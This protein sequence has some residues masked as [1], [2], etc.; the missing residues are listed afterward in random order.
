MAIATLDA[1]LAGMRPPEPFFKATT[2]TLVAG[3]PHSLWYLAGFPGAGAAAANT[4]GG[5]ALSSSS[6]LVA[7]Q[8]RHIDPGGSDVSVL[9]RFSGRVTSQPGHLLLCDR[10]M[11]V[12]GNSGGT[13]LSVTSTSA[14]TINSGTL[15]ARD[16]NASSNGDGVM[17]GMEVVTAT[18]TGANV[19]TFSYTDQDGNA[20]AASALADPYV[21]TSAIGAFYRLGLA[22]GDTGIRS[23]QS[24]TNTVSMTSG[25]ISLVAYRIL[26]DL[27]FVGTGLPNAV[28]ALTS[29]MPQIQNGAVPFLLFIPST[30]TATLIGGQYVESQG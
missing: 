7:G 11:Q 19:P 26:A 24:M 3:R 14:Q 15:P 27:E 20:G 8:I 22:A 12:C 16:V 29:G 13:A 17:W 10:L 25:V 5:V 18:S 4:A 9:A 2:P 21:A 30:T 23:V 6:A 28:D 1:L